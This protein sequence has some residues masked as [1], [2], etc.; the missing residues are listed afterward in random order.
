MAET[1]EERW[2]L[3]MKEKCFIKERS[4]LWT[5]CRYRSSIMID[6]GIGFDLETF[7]YVPI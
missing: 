7:A 4:T 1:L 3:L 2:V 5:I 6:E